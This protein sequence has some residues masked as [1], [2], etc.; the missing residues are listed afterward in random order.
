M[1]RPATFTRKV[2]APDCTGQ[3]CR[4]VGSVMMAASALKPFTMVVSVPTPPL[5][6]PITLSKSTSAAGRK[7]I[8][9]K[10]SSAKMLAVTPAFMS[11][12]PRP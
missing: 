10:V 8:D 3:R 11:Q 12:E 9:C 2:S 6:S 4:R 1:A 7:P 5:S